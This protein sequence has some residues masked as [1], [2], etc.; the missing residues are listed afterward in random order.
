MNDA[1]RNMESHELAGGNGTDLP[2]ELVN[3]RRG[4]RPYSLLDL[5]E[6][7][8]LDIELAAWL[9]S[10]VSRGASF[11]VG[12][13]PGGIGKTT[14]MRALLGFAPG[15]RPFAIALPGKLSHIDGIA[16]CVI[17]HEISDHPPASYLWDQDLRDF[18][19]LS[20][21]GHMLVGNMH[22]DDLDETSAQLS[23]AN[24]VPEAQFRAL[25]L[26]AFIRMEGADPSAERIKDATS[27]RFFGEIF[28]SNGVD[29]HESVFTSQKGLS[30]HAPRDGAYEKLCYEFLKKALSRPSRRIEEA[31]RHFLAWEK[32][33]GEPA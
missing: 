11:I 32:R 9:V 10:H 19:A 13:G 5:I 29:V 4:D 23:D 6:L 31:R 8:T 28:Y 16:S 17:S 33:H 30:A 18:F 27:R 7:G 25:N 24:N 21:K 14:A 12:S 22:A 1:G 3:S 15:N 20:K 26:F 2:E